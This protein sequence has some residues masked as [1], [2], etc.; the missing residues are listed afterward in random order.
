MKYLS[1]LLLV[2]FFSTSCNQ[3]EVEKHISTELEDDIALRAVISNDQADDVMSGI[4][5]FVYHHEDF[6]LNDIDTYYK[7]H[8]SIRDGAIVHNDAHNLIFQLMVEL[9]GLAECGDLDLI[10]YYVDEMNEVDFLLTSAIEPYK[11]CLEAILPLHG[12]DEIA[13]MALTR[14]ANSQSYIQKNFSRQEFLAEYESA[15]KSLLTLSY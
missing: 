9:Y 5:N 14:H 12:K 11:R 2:T 4:N 13:H 15:N 6:N 3:N 7:V 1:I 8:L 10:S